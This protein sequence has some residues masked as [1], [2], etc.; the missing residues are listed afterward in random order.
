MDVKELQ[1]KFFWSTDE[2]ERQMLLETN[3]PAFSLATYSPKA[4]E[5]RKLIPDY[6]CVLL[7]EAHESVSVHS[8]R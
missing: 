5:C 1:E 7:K 2:S 8:S 4:D 3:A 6:I